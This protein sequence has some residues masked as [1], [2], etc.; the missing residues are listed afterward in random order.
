MERSR[1]GGV[2]HDHASHGEKIEGPG[3]RGSL[4][5]EAHHR[6]I[7]GGGAAAV[8]PGFPLP[9]GTG[10]HGGAERKRRLAGGWAQGGLAGGGRSPVGGQDGGNL[11]RIRRV[12]GGVGSGADRPAVGGYFSPASRDSKC[13]RHG[14]RPGEPAWWPGKAPRRGAGA[15]RPNGAVGG[16]GGELA[17]PTGGAGVLLPGRLGRGAGFAESRELDD[18][19]GKSGTAG[20][21]SIIAGSASGAA[22]DR[23]PQGGGGRARLASVGGPGIGT[24][25]GRTDSDRPRQTESGRR[26]TFRQRPGED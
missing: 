21:L 4:G 20:G 7:H 12:D 14:G 2:G 16:S 22:T 13:V 24:G 5:T 23:K 6:C 10:R 3:R 9:A 19:F 1:P 17:G 25:R 18:E 15:E 26:E 8:E 11:C